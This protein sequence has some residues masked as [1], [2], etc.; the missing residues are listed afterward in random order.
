MHTVF[1][2]LLF[3]P[4]ANASAE[5]S[6][7]WVDTLS[8]GV[9]SQ[10]QSRQS[11]GKLKVPRPSGRMAPPFQPRPPCRRQQQC[12]AQRTNNYERDQYHRSEV[13]QDAYAQRMDD[14][15]LFEYGKERLKEMKRLQ[16]EHARR[17]D[18]SETQQTITED[19][20]QAVRNALVD[21]V[22]RAASMLSAVFCSNVLWNGAYLM[23]P[24]N[25]SQVGSVRNA[26]FSAS[27]CAPIVSTLPVEVHLS[28]SLPLQ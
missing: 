28:L 1:L 6:N 4:E 8:T 21:Q 2:R 26:F 27:P 15:L 17:R 18:E 7:Q 3:A 20:P 13:I 9:A 23:C 22:H 5:G 19:D 11:H 16:A 25:V 14:Q 12:I 10:R 24:V